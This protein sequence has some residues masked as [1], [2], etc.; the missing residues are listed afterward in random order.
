MAIHIIRPAFSDGSEKV[1]RAAI[2]C[3]SIAGAS[4]GLTGMTDPPYGFEI[5]YSLN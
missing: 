1:S 3:E 4:P 5:D 2:E